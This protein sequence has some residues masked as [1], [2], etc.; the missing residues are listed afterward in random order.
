MFY[1]LR[2]LDI[3]LTQA[4]RPE[5]P[6]HTLLASGNDSEWDAVSVIEAI[7]LFVSHPRLDLSEDDYYYFI[8]MYNGPSEG[9]NLMFGTE[10][11]TPQVAQSLLSS[12]IANFGWTPNDHRAAII[13]RLIRTRSDPATSRF[14]SS[15]SI[16]ALFF[17][18][19]D[20][21]ECHNLGEKW[22][23]ILDS[24]GVD[25]HS[26]F[27]HAMELYQRPAI[28]HQY[29]FCPTLFGREKKIFLSADPEP[30][31]RWEWWIPLDSPAA[32][33]LE[34]FKDM[35]TVHPHDF[36]R[37]DH[38]K[39]WPFNFRNCVPHA[40]SEDE[41]IKERD[42]SYWDKMAVRIDLTTKRRLRREQRHAYRE[43][44]MAGLGK[45]LLMPGMWVS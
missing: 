22:L 28:S 9:Y 3:L 36:Y 44:K 30:S 37:S 25:V 43:R 26:Y 38:R 35:G 23:A 5:T 4:T 11:F 27:E 1:P 2:L 34:L 29:S 21:F 33:G 18:D 17:L 32:L 10:T 7:G 42:R 14:W 31:I 6:I 8:D 13:T 45:Q 20:P 15:L 40:T 39:H 41:D 12:A 19:W 16:S 24:A